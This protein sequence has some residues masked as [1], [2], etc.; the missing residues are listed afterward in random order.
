M[1]LWVLEHMQRSE[2]K[3]ARALPIAF[4]LVGDGL[5]LL[6]PTRFGRLV[7]VLGGS[8]P[9]FPLHP[10]VGMLGSQV[11]DLSLSVFIQS[12]DPN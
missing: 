9:P 4:S 8:F 3:Q 10:L 11:G 7:G 1:C 5:T 2:D 6:F 12:G